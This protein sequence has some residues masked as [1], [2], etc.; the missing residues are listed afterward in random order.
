MAE[1]ELAGCLRLSSCTSSRRELLGRSGTGF[2]EPDVLPVT[3]P[4]VSKTGRKQEHWPQIVACLNSL[5][6]HRWI[7]EGTDVATLTPALQ[8]R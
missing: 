6:I 5:F 8:R 1:R 2:H 7:P 4:T 3:Q